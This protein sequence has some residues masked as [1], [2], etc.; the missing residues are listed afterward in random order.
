MLKR[1]LFITLVFVVSAARLLAAPTVTTLSPSTGATASSLTSIIVTFSE[2]VTGV[3]ANDLLINNEA[4]LT[5]SG[6]GPY[7]FTFTQPLPGT[8]NVS[9][10]F[11]HGIAGL[12]SGVYVQTTW[13]YT[14]TDTLAPTIAKIKSSAAGEEQDAI[15]PLPGSTMYALSQVEVNFSE[16]VSGVNASDLLVSGVPATGVTGSGAGP[17]VFAFTQLTAGV[18]N[19]QWAAGHG[20]TD[21]AAVPNAFVGGSW[22]VTLGISGALTINEFLA[23]NATGLADENGEQGGWIEIHNR[24]ATAVNLAGW[25]LTDDPEVLGK[26]VFPNRSLAGGAYLVVYASGKDRKPVSGNLHTN[27]KPKLNGGYLALVQPKFPRTVEWQYPS[28]YDPL[29]DPPVTEYPAQR[30][31]YSYG[32]QNPYTGGLWPGLFFSPPTPGTMNNNATVLTGATANPTT[33]VTRG[34]F[35]DAFQLVISCPTAGAT[36]RY[37]LDGSVPTAAS[38][39]YTVPLAISATTVLRLVAF[40]A[41]LIPSETVTHS[42]IF[43]DQVF[44]QTSPPYD[45]PANGGD[46]A[47]PQ[48]PSVGGVPLPVAW[49][50]RAAGGLPGLMTNL[51]TNQVPADYGMDPEIY[52]DANNYDDT[53]AINPTTGKTNMER[54]K[55]GLR[56][57]PIMSVV[58]KTDDMWGAAGMYSNPTVKGPTYE[59]ACSV[60]MILP[61]GSTAFATTCGIRIHGN[62]SRNPESQ[63]KHG[64]NLNF[65]GDYGVSSLDYQ[66]FPDSPA[67]KL[68]NIVLRADYNSSWLHHDGGTS[69]TGQRLRGTRLR[70]AFCK[71]TFR[72]MGRPAGHNRYV[73]LFINGIYWGSYDPAE[74]ESDSFAALYY[75]GDKGDYDIYEQGLLKSGT[76]TA[77]TAMTA[78]APPID[79]PKYEQMKQYLDVSEFIDYMLFHFWTGHQDWGDDINKNWYAV[80]NAKVGGTFK[81]LPWDQENLMFDPAVD[82]TGVVSPASGLHPK[83]VTNTQYLLDF[84]DRTHRHLLAPDGAL[85]AAA[86][87]A[88]FNK[89]KLILTNGIAAESARW[90]DYRRDVH[91]YQVAGPDFPLYTWNGHWIAEANRLTGTWFP[92]RNT[93]AATPTLGLLPQLR[94]RGLYPMQDAAELR[95]NLTNTLLGSQRVAAGFQV[96]MQFP[97]AVSRNTANVAT[98]ITGTIYYTT[99]GSDPRVYYTGTVAAGALAYTGPLTINATTTIKARTL[100]G[101]TWSALNEA[102][103]TV[104]FVPQPVR[105]TEIMYHPTNGQG[106]DA[107]EFIELQ[108]TSGASVDMSGWFFDQVDFI[109]PNGFILGAGDRIVLA[110]NNAPATF[111]GTYPG[112]AVAGYFGGSLSNGGE[113]LALLDATGKTLVAVEYDDETPWPTTPD[114]GGTSLEIIAANGD[115]ASPVNWKASNAVK[116]T[117]GQANSVGTTSSVIISEFLAANSGAYIVSGATPDYVEIYNTSASVVDIGNWQIRSTAA[118]SLVVPLGTMI[119]PGERTLIHFTTASLAGLRVNAALPDTGDTISLMNSVGAVVDSVRYGPQAANFSFSHIGA[120]TFSSPTPGAANSS[121]STAAQSNLRLNEWLANPTPGFD[122]WLEITNPN[123]LPVVLTGLHVSTSSELFLIAAPSA[124]AAGGYAQLLCNRGGTRGDTLDFNLPTAGTTLALIGADGAAVDTLTFGSQSEGVSQGRLPNATGSAVVLPY[125]SPAVANYSAITSSVQ[126][127]EILLTN[128]NGDNAP[129]ARRPSWLE[130]RNPSAS[131]VDLSGWRLRDPRNPGSSWTIPGGVILSADAHLAI[132]A[133][134]AQAGSTTAAPNL[135]SPIALVDGVELVNPAGQIVDR[136]VWGAQLADLSTG[137]IGGGGWALLISPTRGTANTPAATLGVASSL[138]INEWHATGTEFSGLNDYIEL[139][140][141]SAL[142]IALGGLYLSD[143]PSEIGRRKYRIADLSFIGPSG[144]TTLTAASSAPT[145]SSTGYT[146][147]DTGEYI[148]L[149]LS[150]DTQLAA[151]SFGLQANGTAQGSQPEGSATVATFSPS[152][153]LTNVNGT[154]PSFTSS[155]RSRALPAGTAT[156]F[157]LSAVNATGYQ[158]Q[159]NGSPIGGATSPI[160]SIASVSL[161]NDGVYTCVATGLAGSA[162]SLPATLTVLHTYSTWAASYGLAGGAASETADPDGD[163]LSNLAEFLA[164]TNPLLP[165][166]AAERSNAHALG[167]IET[168]AGVPT[169]LTLDLRVNRRAALNAFAGE[170]T[171]SLT[172]SWTPAAPDLTQLISTEGNGDKHWRFKY[173]LPGGTQQKFLRLRITE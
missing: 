130:L 56:D 51:T 8:V 38:T 37:T 142:P 99:N 105:I 17:Y 103:L 13:S 151:V 65:K 64:F 143:D 156:D 157:T 29:S 148:R 62:A 15:V 167:A 126:L 158:W 66:L 44:N 63:P 11:D 28:S 35:T 53:G 110:S 22:S 45:N 67:E 139:Y 5:V 36:V 81:Y 128:L 107:A 84:A 49:G 145:T 118:G 78:I 25:A 73:N 69:L 152:P 74:K 26:W 82:R 133:D 153:G 98:T 124:I 72:A 24:L 46:N 79:Q 134:S 58:L 147:A 101:A 166:T 61:D 27:F 23:G 114:G 171:T 97:A 60:E 14:L 140:N 146:L 92:T 30:Y 87:I 47:N 7:T 54:I 96:K 102:T 144:F 109:F 91:R 163:G 132:W 76:A 50:I 104:G 117:P 6:T 164:N 32:L 162:T 31:D 90:G 115:P 93:N 95:D 173:S 168:S 89:W 77:Y 155:P 3:D 121:A 94:T 113:R 71:D 10:D 119:L 122:D 170:L 165:A 138:R 68:D 42:Y 40:G 83:L 9:W 137:R 48:P 12:G 57:L 116:G 123:A 16:A 19:F 161:V 88:R 150:D 135:N 136:I 85:Q 1:L 80:R 141:T 41:G 59:K 52:S 4:A 21:T 33:S 111:A 154:G 34:F 55:Q 120:W 159:L 100:T 2:A 129:W 160:Y 86:N 131:S 127:N 149:S 172:G 112:V 18:V 169:F 20:I 43:L 125:P 106:G 70:D 39:T 108:N 75:G